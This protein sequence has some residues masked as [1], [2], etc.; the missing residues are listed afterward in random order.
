MP[1]AQHA[2]LFLALIALAPAARAER[3]YRL[4]NYPTLQ[5]ADPGVFHNLSGAITT[6]DNAP[7]DGLLEKEEVLGWDWQSTYWDYRPLQGDSTGNIKPGVRDILISPTEIRLPLD[8]SAFLSLPWR[9]YTMQWDTFP[10]T[11][12]QQPA[13]NPTAFLAEVGFDSYG[14]FWRADLDA[15][16]EDSWL[17]ATFVPEPASAALTGLSLAILGA[18]PRRRSV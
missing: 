12:N 11:I 16:G 7:D 3:V 6:S 8:R 2:I 15:G 1:S 17:I 18:A 14:F 9:Y 10:S 4:V 5:Q 13:Y